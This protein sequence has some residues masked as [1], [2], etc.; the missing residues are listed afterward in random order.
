[1]NYKN[2]ELDGFYIIGLSVR[3]KNED[4]KSQKD[5]A[6]LFSKLI[7]EDLIDQI[8]DKLTY[9]LY[10]V[11]T[12]YEKD[13]Q[14]EFTA[15][16]GCKVQSIE[17]VPEGFTGVEIPKSKY[18][19]YTVKGGSPAEVAEVWEEIWDDKDVNRAYIADFDVYKEEPGVDIYI[20][21]K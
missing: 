14:G 12:D 20:S 13:S 15:I 3:T 9:E 19:H 7:G 18:R 21:V 17:D 11:Y 5:I 1:M 16:V 6:D 4:G 8:P 10:C 2:I